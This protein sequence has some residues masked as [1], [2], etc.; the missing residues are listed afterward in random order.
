MFWPRQASRVKTASRGEQE[1]VNACHF[2]DLL[3][4]WHQEHFARLCRAANPGIWLISKVDKGV[5]VTKQL[6]KTFLL[7]IH[8]RSENSNS[9]LLKGWV[10]AVDS[11]LR[12]FLS[13]LYA[14]IVWRAQ[15]LTLSKREQSNF[16]RGSSDKFF[17][18]I[19]PVCYQLINFRI[20]VNLQ[21]FHVLVDSNPGLLGRR[22]TA[23]PLCYAT[24]LRQEWNLQS[25]FF[26]ILPMFVFAY[27]GGLRW[28]LKYFTI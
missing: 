6:W 22:R 20:A 13:Q 9:Y 21:F 12:C 24:V 10:T 17:K 14:L 2:V 1:R 26:R 4:C 16:S 25:D 5:H 28:F 8:L 7:P 23:T 15:S 11:T 27:F 18:A 3:T 19:L